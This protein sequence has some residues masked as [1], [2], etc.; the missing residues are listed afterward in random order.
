MVNRAVLPGD[1]PLSDAD[2][3]LKGLDRPCNP[4]VPDI[5]FH[6]R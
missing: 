4:L 3:P 5:P 1:L 6:V 2:Y